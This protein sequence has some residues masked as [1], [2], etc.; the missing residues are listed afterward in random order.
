[1]ILLEKY[2]IIEFFIIE[3]QI[4][5]G[6]SVADILFWNSIIWFLFL[7]ETFSEDKNSGTT[8]FAP[9]YSN[10][11]LFFFVINCFNTYYSYCIDFSFFLLF[12]W[13]VV[14]NLKFSLQI[15]HHLSI[16]LLLVFLWKNN[17]IR[18]SFFGCFVGSFWSSSFSCPELNV[19]LYL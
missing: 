8:K 6:I 11:C 16:K 3:I 9:W 4:I 13:N 15:R 18:I 17:I 2:F 7:A 1:M 19:S 14:N 10:M 5:Y 12:F